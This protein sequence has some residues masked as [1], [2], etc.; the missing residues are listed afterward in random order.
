MTNEQFEKLISQLEDLNY[1]INDLA[2]KFDHNNGPYVSTI[3]DK[4]GD[5]VDHVLTEKLRKDMNT[6][7]NK[8]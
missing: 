7:L 5:L 6:H 8:N 3:G 2:S 1:N 4:L